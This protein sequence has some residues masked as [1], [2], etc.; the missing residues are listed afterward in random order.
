MSAPT[1]RIRSAEPADY[2]AL[3]RIHAQPKVI[4]G[5]L[6]M[7][8]PSVESWRKRMADPQDGHRLLLAC[9][10]EEVVGCISL[11]QQPVSSRRR[12]TAHIGMSVHDD[13][14]GKG[15]GTALMQAVVDLADRWLNL[16]RLELSVY[17]DNTAAIALYKKFGF[18]IEGT[19]EHYAF[20]DGRFTD[21][22]AMARVR[23]ASP[24]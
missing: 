23:P 2:P 3:Q 8:F 14:Q 24:T 22:Y 19:H 6:Q 16:T 18:K 5:T 13:W 10:D 15:V 11:Q 12:H 9:A 21:A 4:R 7:P 20:V 1:I 17:T